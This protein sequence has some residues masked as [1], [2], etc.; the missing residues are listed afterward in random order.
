VGNSNTYDALHLNNQLCFALYAATRAITKVY[1]EKLGP[2]GL[3][4]PQFLV[5]TVLWENDGLSISEIGTE[6][7]LDSGTLTP[8]LKRLETMEIVTRKRS[9]VDER[10]VEIWLTPKGLDLRDTAI[11]AR[12]NVVCRLGMDEGE[13]ADLRRE[14]LEL[15]AKLERDQVAVSTTVEA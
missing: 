15:I 1:R 6:L 3:T 5:L 9:T 12:K 10:E 7:M 14:L 2:A 11:D 8:L 4:Y 13:I